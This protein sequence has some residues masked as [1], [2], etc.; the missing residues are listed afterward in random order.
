MP[1]NR[2]KTLTGQRDGRKVYCA[3]FR[4]GEAMY[5][6]LFQQ[7]DALLLR[8]RD[9]WQCQPMQMAWPSRWPTS[10]LDELQALSL[11]ACLDIDADSARQ[12][13]CFERFFP[14]V[15][16]LQPTLPQSAPMPSPLPFWLATDVPGRKWQQISHFAAA[17][18]HPRGDV[19]APVL[20]WCAGKG[21]LGRALA[22]AGASQVT[23]LEWQA[24]LCQ[25]GQALSDK[26]KLPQTFV[27]AD[28]LAGSPQE[29][30]HPA[31]R[32]VAMHACGDLHR[33]AI[34]HGAKQ[35]VAEMAVLPCCYH[36]QQAAV[37]Q[38]LSQAAQVSSLQLSKADLRLAVQQHATGGA[39]VQRLSHTEMLW[40]HAWRHWQEMHD[41][42]AT[43]KPLQS[44]PKHIF[45]QGL[46]AFFAKA[47]ELHQLAVPDET[48]WPELLQRAEQSLL[49]QRRLELVQHVFRR[50]LELWLVLDLVLHLQEGG[51]TVELLELCEA[52]LTPRNL[53]IRAVRQEV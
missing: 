53:L 33:V 46:A 50:P 51:Y 52:Q 23:S 8:H 32:L 37:Y 7:L 14:D 9:F 38:P 48:L 4:L 31:Q 28:V 10:L 24:S 49:Q 27:C 3:F 29:Y 19:T 34:R 42:E 30:L 13:H 21:H 20:E 36:L 43:Y 41:S 6:Q 39:R 16:Q 45:S 26:L 11:D 40:R 5:H 17:M 25:Q 47:S 2:Q 18:Q 35:Q 1:A 44:L 22:F 15:F 12:R